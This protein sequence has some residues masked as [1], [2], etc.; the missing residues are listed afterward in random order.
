M[1][2]GAIYLNVIH[3][4]R[5]EL[6]I[7]TM[8]CWWLRHYQV[9]VIAHF[10]PRATRQVLR[11]QTCRCLLPILLAAEGHTRLQ[12]HM[13]KLRRL[14]VSETRCKT[15]H[16]VA[17]DTKPICAEAKAVILQFNVVGFM[18]SVQCPSYC[19]EEGKWGSF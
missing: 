12:P 14:H 13:P 3:T 10:E 8:A 19:H 6:I 18:Q 2:Y 7:L 17:P 1:G 15:V 11:C 5:N 16:W 9:C 4:F